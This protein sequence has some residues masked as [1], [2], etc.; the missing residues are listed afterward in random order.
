MRLLLYFTNIINYVLTNIYYVPIKP[1][2]F[3]VNLIN[4]FQ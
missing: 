4:F 1:I 2:Y 3:Y